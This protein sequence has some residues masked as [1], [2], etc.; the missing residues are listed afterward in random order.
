MN[1]NVYLVPSLTQP[2]VLNSKTVIVVDILR[3]TSTMVSAIHHGAKSIIPC[4]EI[5]QAKAAKENQLA[6]YCC[7]ERGGEPI[8]GFDFGNSPMEYSRSQVSQKRLAFTTTNGTKAMNACK[9][10]K[11]IWIGSFLNLSPVANRLLNEDFEVLCA[12]T[13][14]EVTLEDVLYAGCLID[15][16]DQKTNHSLELNDQAKLALQSWRSLGPCPTQD[17]LSKALRSSRG[18]R[19]LIRLGRDEDIYFVAE[20]DKFPILVELEIE[21]WAIRAVER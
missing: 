13:D 4:M 15:E 11:T 8:D 19:N 14:G 7:G 1:V 17:T 6:D 16:V 3:A 10:S 5:S 20:I 9:N 2:E 12:G 21:Q 18:G